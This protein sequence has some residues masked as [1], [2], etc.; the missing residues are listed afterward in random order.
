MGRGG[1]FPGN[2][3]MDAPERSAGPGPAPLFHTSVITPLHA[4]ITEI[5]VGAGLIK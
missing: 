4:F 1:Y 3:P 2:R 5:E